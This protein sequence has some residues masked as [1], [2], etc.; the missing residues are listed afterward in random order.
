MASKDSL[1]LGRIGGPYG[2]KGLGSR[3]VVH[4]PA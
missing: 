4:E 3:A 2:I 1:E